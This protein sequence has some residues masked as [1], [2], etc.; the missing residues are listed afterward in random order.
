MKSHAWGRWTYHLD[1]VAKAE[2][3]MDSRVASICRA[4]TPFLLCALSPSSRTEETSHSTSQHAAKPQRAQRAL[5]KAALAPGSQM[6]GNLYDGQ[7]TPLFNFTTWRRQMG[8][9]SCAYLLTLVTENNV[10][11]GTATLNTF[12]RLQWSEDIGTY[13]FSLS[14][15]LPHGMAKPPLSSRSSF[16][17]SSITAPPVSSF[18]SRQHL[19]IL[20]WL[21]R[22]K[23]LEKH[24]RNCV[25]YKVSVTV[26]GS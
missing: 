4:H 15:L 10:W 20:E 2:G 5:V 1:Y 16:P 12:L 25:R 14:A 24:P 9:F 8:N 17:F 23:F 21:S 6:S 18:I 19:I 3:Y 13:F 22:G 26:N 7:W 11:S